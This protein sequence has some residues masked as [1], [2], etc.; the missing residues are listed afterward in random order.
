[1]STLYVAMSCIDGLISGTFYCCSNAEHVRPLSLMIM[2]SATLR[3]DIRSQTAHALKDTFEKTTKTHVNKLNLSN[4]F[5]I[6]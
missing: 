1:M 5:F 4:Y 2:V 3:D 6:Y